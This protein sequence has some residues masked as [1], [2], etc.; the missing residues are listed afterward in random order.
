MFKLGKILVDVERGSFSLPHISF[1]IF[2][3]TCIVKFTVYCRRAIYFHR[4]NHL[5]Y[6]LRVCS[7][8]EIMLDQSLSE[9][10]L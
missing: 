8:I 7:R 2:L 10:F 4:N 6:V 1:K 3:P 5:C 9:L